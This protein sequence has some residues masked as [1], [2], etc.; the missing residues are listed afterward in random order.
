M[1]IA[2]PSGTGK[3]IDAGAAS[4]LFTLE[5]LT[6]TTGRAAVDGSVARTIARITCADLIVIDD[7][8]MLRAGQAASKAFP[9]G[10]RLRL[11]TPLLAVTSNLHPSG[12][13]TIM[14]RKLATATVD[15]RPRHADRPTAHG[16]T[17][18][19]RIGGSGCPLTP[20]RL[21]CPNGVEQA[22]EAAAVTSISYRAI[23]PPGVA[24]AG[25]MLLRW[26]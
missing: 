7:I 26:V 17:T 20:C 8:G 14:Q 2:G 25:Q 16:E 1:A 9:S 19:P 22:E 3:T 24:P 18:C 21:P 23:Q 4:F 12:F 11:R 5:S 13:D 10:G 15:R 6:T